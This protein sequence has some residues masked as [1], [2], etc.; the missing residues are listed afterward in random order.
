MDS[1]KVSWKQFLS[2]NNGSS[3]AYT[4]TSNTN[5]HFTVATNALAPALARFAAF[6]HSPLFSPSCTSR[7]LNAVDSEHKK[8]HQNDMWRIFQL[9][10]HLSKDGHVWSKFGSGNRESLSKAG[11]ELKSKGRLNGIASPHASKPNGTGTPGI[12]S[13]NASLAPSPIPSRMSS[14]APSIASAASESDADGGAI[15][16]E[17]RRRL[18]EWWTKEYCASRMRLCVIGK[19]SVLIILDEQATVIYFWTFRTTGRV[20]RPCLQSLFTCSEP[21]SGSHPD[22]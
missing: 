9:N 13:A 5:Y 14:P 10:K 12:L 6:F 18:V 4:A 22:G 19:G 1:N 8:N 15:G 21:W 16:R 17:T 20:G 2:K 3:N 11:K 7:E